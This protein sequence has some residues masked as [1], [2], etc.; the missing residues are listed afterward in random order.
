MDRAYDRRDPALV[1]VS[2]DANFFISP[3]AI[4]E[5]G[6]GIGEPSIPTIAG[7]TIKKRTYEPVN[8]NEGMLH[9]IH[10]ACLDILQ[11]LCQLRQAANETSDSSKPKT[12]EAFCEALRQQRIRNLTE[13]DDSRSVKGYNVSYGGIEWLHGYYGAR[14]FWS[15]K[16][17]TEQGWEVRTAMHRSHVLSCR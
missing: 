4:W 3:P 16:W 1:N 15:D 9:P 13:P 8:D 12:L 14:Q 5:Y 17:D 11:R 6:W 10:K 7:T 2:S